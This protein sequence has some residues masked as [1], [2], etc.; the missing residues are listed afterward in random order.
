MV[1]NGNTY[2]FA[3]EGKIYLNPEIC[4][5]D[6]AVHEYTHLWDNYCQKTNPEL[7]E[8]GKSI[9]KD[10][11]YW[12]EVKSD[13]NY[14]DIADN[15]DLVLSEIHSRI[16]GKMA[17]SVLTK[18][19]EKDGKITKDKVIDWD[20]ETWNYIYNSLHI[21]VFNK[22]DKTSDTFTDLKYFLVTLFFLLKFN[23]VI[24]QKASGCIR[25]RE[26]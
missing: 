23:A 6:V 25:C 15:D 24:L 7:W 17:D 26:F 5:S 21:S 13:P 8:K 2:G 20:D 10:T 19:A 1:Q 18:I 3:Y 9:L 22:L 4:N 16:C 11:Y 12:N 14:T